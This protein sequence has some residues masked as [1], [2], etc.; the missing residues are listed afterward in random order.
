MQQNMLFAADFYY[1]KLNL[2][3]ALAIVKKEG[4]TTLKL[5]NDCI[6]TETDSELICVSF[7][8]TFC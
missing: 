1:W 4:E 2:T 8:S 7:G 3:K 5:P 6:K